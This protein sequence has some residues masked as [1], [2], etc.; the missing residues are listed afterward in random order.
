MFEIKAG[1][2]VNG[3]LRA[4]FPALGYRLFR[5]LGVAPILVPDDSPQPL[6]EYELNLFAAKPDRVNAMSQQGFLVDAIAA[7]APNADDSKK[8][9]LFWR[10]SEICA[11]DQLVWRK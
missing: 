5:Q 7:W 8:A 3:R 2:K 11:A 1:D 10:I 6:D 9:D 4:L